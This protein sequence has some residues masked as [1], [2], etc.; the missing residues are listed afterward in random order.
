MAPQGVRNLLIDIKKMV[1]NK[2]SWQL[3]HHSRAKPKI[4]DSIKNILQEKADYIVVNTL[5]PRHI[6]PPPNDIDFNYLSDIHI[7][8]YRNYLYFCATY[9]FHD[10]NANIS[11]FEMR[12]ARMEYIDIDS[13]SI[14]YWRHTEEWFEV[15][16]KLPMLECLKLIIEEPQ[17]MP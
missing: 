14:S 5:K 8:W 2:K 16:H 4:P 15:Y 1:I 7:K 17:F 12:F 6:K 10:S 9:S 11:S 3:T 13:F